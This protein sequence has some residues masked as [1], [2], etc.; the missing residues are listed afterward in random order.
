MQ[1]DFLMHH[2]L[3]QLLHRPV[4][5]DC[6]D[7][8]TVRGESEVR[9]GASLH[10]DFVHSF[11]SGHVPLVDRPIVG[12][13]DQL[14]VV[15]TPLYGGDLPLV[16]FQHMDG[17]E[18]DRVVHM[19]CVFCRCNQQVTSVGKQ[20][21]TGFS[22]RKLVKDPHVVDED[23]EEADLVRETGGNVKAIRMDADAVNL[24]VEL[25][26]KLQSKCLV[27]PDPGK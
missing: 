17:F 1:V 6:I 8:L 13:R 26:R 9:E 5:A 3:H 18:G 11:P 25:F 14:Q 16:A 10:N 12:A 22:Y 27:V 24:L 2:R 15:E 21:D 4:R 19:D 20:A 23:V 7:V